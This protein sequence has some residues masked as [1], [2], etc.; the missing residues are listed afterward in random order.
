MFDPD[1]ESTAT[2]R[3]T[4]EQQIAQLKT[5]RTS[6]NPTLGRQDAVTVAL[7]DVV[8][9]K[10]ET[11]TQTVVFTPDSVREH[12]AKKVAEDAKHVHQREVPE[13]L[14]K[15]WKTICNRI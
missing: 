4:H 8:V 11:N 12:V 15:A 3:I 7:I 13:L 5:L 6:L 1:R 2:L 9:D 10:A 14:P